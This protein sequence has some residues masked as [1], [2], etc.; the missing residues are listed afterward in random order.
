MFSAWVMGKVRGTS[1]EVHPSLLLGALLLAVGAVASQRAHELGL[2]SGRAS[3]PVLLAA[4]L[5]LGFLVSVVLHEL[6]HL[7]VARALGGR[8]ERLTFSVIGGSSRFVGLGTD[9]FREGL[10][11]AA[12]PATSA[13][14]GLLGVL[15][16]R[17][18]PANHPGLRLLAF[19]LAQLNL[20]LAVLN[21]VP[22]WPLD[23]GK[24]LRTFLSGKLGPERAGRVAMV[25]GWLLAGLLLVAGLATGAPVLLLV[26]LLV[27]LAAVAEPV[28]V[29]PTG[30]GLRVADVM[31]AAPR[32]ISPD[33]TLEVLERRLHDEHQAGLLV[34]GDERLVGLVGLTRLGDVLPHARAHTRVSE[35]MAC[36]AHAVG[37]GTLLEAARAQMERLRVE[38]LPVVSSGEVVGVVKSGVAQQAPRAVPLPVR[39]PRIEVAPTPTAPAPD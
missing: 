19:D 3:S 35:V 34:V 36:P 8:A 9:A 2:W 25:L 5:G 10:V 11:E 22:A 1:I 26:A 28:E 7:A 24:V 37:P 12:G 33:A 13:V 23:G 20:V 32:P 39:A 21:L 17:L 29:A 38:L 14:L 15:A 27:A 30:P 16:F 18:V 6:A 31:V 4:G